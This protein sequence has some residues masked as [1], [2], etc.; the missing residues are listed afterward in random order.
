[1][2]YFLTLKCIAMDFELLLKEQ[3]IR[4][5][6]EFAELPDEELVLR[7]NKQVRCLG[8]NTIRKVFLSALR[9]ELGQRNF[10]SSIVFNKCGL[11]LNHKVKLQDH[12]LVYA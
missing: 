7:F 4:F 9:E 2:Q 3:Q 12:R 5:Q 6:A 10:D 11:R 1:M 8:G